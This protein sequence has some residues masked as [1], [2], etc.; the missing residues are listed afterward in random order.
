MR[1]SRG[2]T[3][4]RKPVKKLEMA[5]GRQKGREEDHEGTRLRRSHQPP[6]QRRKD[7][8]ERPRGEER[9]NRTIQDTEPWA[10]TGEIQKETTGEKR[11]RHKQTMGGEKG[12][13]QEEIT[14]EKKRDGRE[15]GRRKAVSGSEMD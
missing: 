10:K 9:K 15:Q 11:V 13:N 6:S 12:E 1:Q 5:G 14:L 7:R 4:T 2:T 3:V 8:E